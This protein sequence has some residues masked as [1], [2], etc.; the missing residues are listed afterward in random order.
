LPAVAD[1]GFDKN[2][3][4]MIANKPA[5][6]NLTRRNA[7]F[8]LIELLVVIAIIAILAAM[9]LPVL[10]KAKQKA[11]QIS[12]LNNLKQLAL[13]HSMY[14]NDYGHGIPDA[15]PST[16]TG[17]WFINFIDYYG[18]ATN[19]LKCPTTSQPATV[20]NNFLG[21]SVTPWCKTDYAGSGAA[22]IGSYVINGWFSTDSSGTVGKGDGQGSQQ[23][24]YFKDSMINNSS[25]TPVFSD[26]IWVDMWPM[27]TDCPYHDLHGVAQLNAPANM[28]GEGS[29]GASGGHS[30]ARTCTARH[31]CNATAQ[32]SWTSATATPQGAINVGFFD[33]HVEL[34]KLPKLW[35]LQW[36]RQWGVATT[37]AI[38]TPY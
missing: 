31:A 17:S 3:M 18:K 35:T 7:G 33:G 34:T 27:E 14:F 22:Y 11:Q 2:Q 26:G 30:I 28:S 4:N 10:A 6:R 16:S 8:T 25:A 23:L 32:N 36:H 19:V 13:A 1:N 15:A 29:F 37:P 24:Y 20:Q 9:L 12:C 21:N 38:G 5:S